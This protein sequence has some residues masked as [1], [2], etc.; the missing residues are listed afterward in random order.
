M[1]VVIVCTANVCR[2]PVAELLWRGRAAERGRAI[3]VS[4][5]GIDARPGSVAD[6]L[7][8]AL[9]AERGLDLRA[10]RARRLGMAEAARH[11]LIL[12]MEPVHAQR[13]KAKAPL[14]AGRVQ[15]LGRWGGGAIADPRGASR[16]VYEQCLG[17]IST[18]V[19]QWLE[20]L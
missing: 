20:R 3:L 12:V 16:E 9:L 14:L 2:S 19:D 10:H 13:I 5:A 6:P 17:V 4:S 8:V 11:D 7:C 15:L 1:S 18:A